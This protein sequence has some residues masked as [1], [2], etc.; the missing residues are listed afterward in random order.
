M[1]F[2]LKPVSGFLRVDL[3]RDSIVTAGLLK[4]NEHI[5]SRL[6]IPAD[7]A[8]IRRPCEAGFKVDLDVYVLR[9]AMVFVPDA[10]NE[11][12]AVFI[13]DRPSEV[14]LAGNCQSEK[15]STKEITPDSFPVTSMVPI[16][17]LGIFV[18]SFQLIQVFNSAKFVHLHGII[19]ILTFRKRA[20]R[21]ESDFN[22]FFCALGFDVNV[23]VQRPDKMNSVALH[24]FHHLKVLGRS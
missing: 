16:A 23:P 6:R 12:A 1:Q 15:R 3:N 20:V 4:R 13:N 21:T 18:F 17:Q 24:T 22:C 7:K 2:F 9:S 19:N 11:F 8:G 14:L 10:L 5:G